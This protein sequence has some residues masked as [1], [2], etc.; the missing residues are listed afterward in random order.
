MKPIFIIL[1]VVFLLL[2]LAFLFGPIIK[3]KYIEVNY[4]K[5]V[6]KT[7]YKH[8]TE[9]NVIPCIILINVSLVL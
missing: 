9:L 8:I 6:S 2:L 3:R 7:L 5:I 4:K 1:L